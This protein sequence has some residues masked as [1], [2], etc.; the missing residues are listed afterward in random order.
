VKGIPLLAAA[1]AA[2]AV[3]AVASAGANP[4]PHQFCQ[5]QFVAG[6]PLYDG[7]GISVRTPSGKSLVLCRVTV[8]PP[9]ETIVMTFPDTNGDIV[10]ITQSGAAIVVFHG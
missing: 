6:G 9:P 8:P 5:V 10:V 7:V 3:P 2:L 1:V 4:V